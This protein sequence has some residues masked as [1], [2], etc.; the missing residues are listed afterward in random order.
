MDWEHHRC[1]AGHSATLHLQ[2]IGTD[3]YLEQ[4]WQKASKPQPALFSWHVSP[5]PNHWN[6]LPPRHVGREVPRDWTLSFSICFLLISSYLP[7]PYL[8]L[9]RNEPNSQLFSTQFLPMTLHPFHPLTPGLACTSI[10]CRWYLGQTS[11][12]VLHWLKAMKEFAWHFFRIVIYKIIICFQ[13][14]DP[15]EITERD[16]EDRHM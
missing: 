13:L 4:D 6:P 15:I 16:D 11:S 2:R 1:S 10:R 8:Y 14:V 12:T 9:S 3:N 7:P 5:Y